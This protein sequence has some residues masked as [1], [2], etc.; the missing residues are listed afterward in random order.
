LAQPDTLLE[1]KYEILSRLRE[2]GMGTIYLVRHRLLDKIR[3]IKVLRAHVSADPDVKR[4]FLDEA[5]M[6]TRLNHPNLCTI[7]DFAID[8]DATGYLVMEY[9]EGVNLAELLAMQGP[10][11]LPLSLEII[12]QTLLAL[13]YLHR[14]NV[15]HRDVAADN[16][17]LTKTEEGRPLVKIIDL[18]IAKEADRPIEMTATGVFLGKLRYASPEQ[19]GSLG[20]G[21]RLDGR[22]DL[23]S[24]GIVLYELVTG[25]RPFTGNSPAELLRSQL[26]N[27]PLPFEQSD[28]KGLVP[29]EL[30]AAILKALQKNRNDRYASA[31]DFDQRIESIR[32]AHAGED[33]DRTR[34]LLSRLP[35]MLSPPSESVTPSAQSR[36]DHQFAGGTTPH[37][38][39]LHLTIAPTV[40]ATESGIP[41]APQ[42]PVASTYSAALGRRGRWIAFLAAAALVAVAAFV[43]IRLRPQAP[44]GESRAASLRESPAAT[45]ESLA[46]AIHEEPAATET[47]P[48]TPEPLQPT[49]E[50][51]PTERPAPPA[52]RVPVAESAPKRAATAVPR[53]PTES[54]AFVRPAAP[55]PPPVAVAIAAPTPPPAPAGAPEPARTAAAAVEKPA[56]LPPPPAAPAAIT[57][58]D[59]IRETIRRYEKAQSTLDADAYARVFPSVDRERIARAFQSLASQS[60]EFEIRKIQIDPSGTQARVDGY[61]KRVA[62]PRAGTEQRVSADRVL[63]LEKRPEGWVIVRLN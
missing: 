62:A 25:V 37:P 55:P 35:T 48:P 31:E 32:R 42:P 33:A 36:I 17:M 20:S 46:P 21:E 52:A 44:P 19:A 34:V 18:G 28:P 30:R 14:K 5:R 53:K 50:P 51:A 23:Y 49:A 41:T 61:E 11:G 43:M 13:G 60:V 22:S 27:P 3:V 38:A 40:S 26:F 59:R 2:G 45:T 57:E 6:A 9:I 39:N 16:L 63:Q 58:S 29:A 10:P 8:E 15:V 54:V 47:A 4:R 56:A 12:H 7:H 24:L 1:G